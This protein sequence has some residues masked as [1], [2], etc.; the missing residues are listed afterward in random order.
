[1]N[2]PGWRR[3][4]STSPTGVK[5]SFGRPV[6]GASGSSTFRRTRT[7][8]STLVDDP[9]A[10][11]RVARWRR[12]LIDLLAQRPWDGLSDGERLISG[13]LLPTLRPERLEPDEQDKSND[14][15][16]EVPTSTRQ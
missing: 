2:A 8:S 13:T 10:A 4:G 6:A 11:T 12:R 7:N 14:V 5:S 1:M 9:R 16:S 3:A 15:V